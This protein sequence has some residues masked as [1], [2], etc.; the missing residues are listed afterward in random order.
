V[1]LAFYTCLALAILCFWA[2]AAFVVHLPDP[3][4]GEAALVCFGGSIA[5]TLVAVGIA[6]YEVARS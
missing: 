6:R 5:F 4:F 1:R 3:T 2:W